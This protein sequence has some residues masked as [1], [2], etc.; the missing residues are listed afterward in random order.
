M[1]F[2][3]GH[4]IAP[5]RDGERH[6]DPELRFLANGSANGEIPDY[7]LAAWL[8]AAYL[9]PLDDEETAWLTQAMADSGER[10]DLTG[11]PKPW[12]D[13]HSTGGVGDKT[14]IVLLPMLV[15]CGLTVVKMS[16]RGLGP[17][18]GTLDKLGA[19]TG[20]RTDLTADEMK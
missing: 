12:V 16:G 5:R 15:A 1:D 13:K 17:T 19:V 2:D 10:I 18:G 14:S 20:F 7:Q 9:N 8:M 6:T 11:L 3:F 4:I